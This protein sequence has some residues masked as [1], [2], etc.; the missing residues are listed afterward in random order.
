MRAID[1]QERLGP[2][3]GHQVR[4][5]PRAGAF[6]P[7]RDHVGRRGE[8]RRPV[9]QHPASV[10]GNANRNR[11]VPVGIQILEDGRRRGERDLVLTRSPAVDDADT[12]LL[13]WVLTTEDTDDTEEGFY[14]ASSASV[15]RCLRVPVVDAYG[16]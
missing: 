12:K 13:H 9:G 1:P 15:A 11:F 7:R 8:L 6:G 3:V 16:L 4:L 2:G 5:G 10:L 14:F